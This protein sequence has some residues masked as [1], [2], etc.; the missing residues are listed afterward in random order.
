VQLEIIRVHEKKNPIFI[1]CT[2]DET[3]RIQEIN[4][5]SAISQKKKNTYHTLSL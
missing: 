4:C 3:H 5:S 2:F 1:M